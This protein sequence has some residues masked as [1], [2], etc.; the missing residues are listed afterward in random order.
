MELL[1]REQAGERIGLSPRS[2]DRLAADG[3]IA[4]FR[5]GP[6]GGRVRFAPEDLDDYVRRCRKFGPREAPRPATKRRP[7]SK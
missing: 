7:K 2:I 5:L 3:E 6:K 4:V 1:T